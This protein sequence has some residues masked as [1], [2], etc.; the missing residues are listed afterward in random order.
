[1]QRG[2]RRVGVWWWD[3]VKRRRM[4][5]QNEREKINV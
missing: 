1:V 3:R 4:R 5:A 2:V